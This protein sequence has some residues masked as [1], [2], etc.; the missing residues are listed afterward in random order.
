MMRLLPVLLALA[1]CGDKQAPPATK[2]R[3][4]EAEATVVPATP[5]SATVAVRGSV[6]DRDTREPVKDVEVVL[7]GASGD[8]TTRSGADGTFK[9][10]V[11][12]GAYRAFVRDLRVMSTGMQGRVRL[13]TLPRTEHAGAA[14]EKLMPLLEVD[15]DTT[16]VELTVTVGA[17]VNGWIT[18]PAGKPEKDVV[19]TA[20]SVERP[21]SRGTTPTVRPAVVRRTAPRPVLGTDTAIS[22]ADGHFI[23]RVPAG[24]YELVASSA[25]YAGIAGLSEIVL[26]A[27]AHLDTNLTLASGCIITGKVVTASGTPPHDGAI[28]T[29][30]G[31]ELFGPTGR[32]NADGTF[33]WTTTELG[34]VLIRAWPW[35]Q[36]ASETRS[37]ECTHGKRHT[38]VELKL[39]NAE[40]DIAG[41]ISDA[42]GNPVPLAYVDI[43][44]LDP[45]ERGQQ[46][47]ADASGHWEVF[48]MRAGRYQITASAAGRGIAVETITAPRRD[49]A[50]HL[51]G[52]GRIAGTTTDLVDGSFE[53]TFHHCGA[54]DPIEVDDDA[55]IVVVRGGRFTVERV[56]ACTLTMTARWRDKLL[57]HAVVVEPDRTA[58]MELALGAPRDKKVR[59]TVRDN[60]GKP[61]AN[62][63]VTALVDHREATTVRSDH[64]G[65]F[66]LTIPGGAQLVAGNGTLVG[67]ATV[68]RANIATEQ[69]DIALDTK[70]EDF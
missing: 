23:L 69:V 5:P 66:E 61:V 39:P 24:S 53:L 37:F 9:I 48:D 43:A 46:E 3:L 27:G 10:S 36:P 42:Y 20:V 65:H 14:D 19:V 2:S 11:A 51:S 21:S 18:D 6:L 45:G 44:P 26:T 50:L 4:P 67:R 1:A 49:V 68:G 41:T 30:L 59:G 56:P 64:D 15:G 47:R 31:L 35:Q 12:R 63:R 70:A 58:S 25:K 32:V 29:Q 57:T 55:R 54:A 34:T 33:K 17:L 60:A 28:E 52:T 16:G 38:N 7:R 22:D 62:A 40:P 13:R 8:V